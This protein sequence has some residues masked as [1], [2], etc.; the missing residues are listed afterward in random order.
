MREKSNF[1]WPF[2]LIWVVQ[3]RAQKYSASSSPQISGFLLP[4]RPDQR[5]VRVV[6]DVGPECGGR[7][8]VARER[9]RRAGQLVSGER[10]ARRAVLLRTEKSCGSGAP[11]L[12]LRFVDVARSPTGLRGVV[13]CKTTVAKEPGHREEHEGHR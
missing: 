11:T 7:E 12:A 4:S 5:G 2:K 6:T 3:S 13:I 10:R 9:D 8:S 1:A